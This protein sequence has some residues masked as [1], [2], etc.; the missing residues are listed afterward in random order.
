MSEESAVAPAGV[1]SETEQLL[2]LMR[3]FVVAK[4][5]HVVATLGVADRLG[6][7]PRP[8]DQLAQEVE[9][10]PDALFRML[11]ALSSVGL[12]EERT[13]RSFVLTKLGERLRAGVPGSLRNWFLTNG[14]PIYNAFGG[15]VHSARTGKPAFDLV[16]GMSFFDY[17]REHPDEGAIFNA[18][19]HEFT[20]QANSSLLASYDFRGVRHVVDVGGGGGALM[21]GLLEAHPDTSG[22]IFDLPHVVAEARTSPGISALGQRAQVVGG[23]FFAEI[24]P[25]ADMYI[26]AWILHDWDD[27]RATAIL[28]SCRRAITDGGR[29]LVLEAILPEGNGPHFSKFG[30][31]VMLVLFGSR[32]RTQTEYGRLLEAAGFRITRVVPTGSPRS[33]IEAVPS[34]R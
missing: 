1:P 32:E 30:D 6:G 9:A 2:S 25:G 8:V 18:A 26:L 20:R 34:F 3:G 10:N 12:F 5:I 21:L 31:I 16:Y 22:T 13:G 29:L 23:D 33:L 17:L 27:E 28:Q 24:P 4:T 11:R 14:G 19:M 15:A 7:D